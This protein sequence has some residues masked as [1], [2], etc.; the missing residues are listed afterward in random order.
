[1]KHLP[2][3]I[4]RAFLA[5][6]FF[7]FILL[8]TNVVPAYA[9][10]QDLYL[11]NRINTGID[12]LYSLKFNEAAT[13]FDEIIAKYP[14]EPAGYFFRSQIHLWKYLFDYSE[15]DFRLFLQACDKAIS[16]AETRLKQNP[17]D[18]FAGAVVGAV[19]GFRAMA[20]FR[21]ENYI[22]ATLDG[23]SCYNY[24]TEVIKKNPSEYDAYLGLG[25]FHFGI[26][27]LPKEIRFGAN[28]AGLKGDCESGLREIEQVAERST[29][30]RNDAK[31]F[32]AMI[33]VYYKQDFTRGLKYLNDLIERFP[34]NLPVLYTLGNVEMLL[35]KPQTALPFYRRTLQYA[36]TNFRTYTAFANYRIAE[37]HFR[38]N[39]FDAAKA[40]FQ[41]FFKGKYERSFRGMALLRLSLCYELAGN[42]SEAQKGYAKCAQLSP[43]EPDDKFAIRRAKE[44]IKNPPEVS[45]I[46]LLKG[47]NCVES[48]RFSEAEKFLRPLVENS[49]LSKE[50]RS[51]AA[52]NLGEVLREQGRGAEAILLYL[53]VIEYEPERER[54][55]MPWSYYRIATI[56]YNAGKTELS[57]SFLDKAKVFSKYDF[58]EW[59][60]FNMYRDTSLLKY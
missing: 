2:T 29:W 51:E 48:S 35:R 34:N 58:E 23:R 27:V 59:L 47:V 14:T 8:F 20:N 45:Q 60:Q 18:T 44:Y 43:F 5:L 13:I 38:L 7:F 17:N 31:M 15:N 57:R 33:N 41:R 56:H 4:Q 55:T 16:I 26:G 36:D 12:A 42:R 39:E 9:E 37:A 11:K 40:A 10:I 32:L 19:Y 46:Q 3:Q 49:S 52:Y 50:I 1:M 30:A 25:I 24:L 53:K 21:A 22:N 54:W 28:F 6:V